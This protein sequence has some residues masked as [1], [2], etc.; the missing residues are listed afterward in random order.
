MRYFVVRLAKIV[1]GEES[2]V[3]PVGCLYQGVAK[4]ALY[5][6]G[7]VCTDRLRTLA[8]KTT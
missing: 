2:F 7:L 1:A 8:I 3:N 5:F 6:L 4:P